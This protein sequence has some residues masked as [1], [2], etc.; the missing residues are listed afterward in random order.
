MYNYKYN[1][2]ELQETGMYD[3]GAR[4]Y[5][6]DIGRWGV[7][8]PLAEKYRR[9]STYAY[10]VNNPIRFI[11]PD[12]RQ[13]MDPI[14][15]RISTFKNGLKLIGDDGKN[16]GRAYIAMGKIKRAVEAT[17]KKGE[18]YKG[19]LAEGNNVAIIPTGDRLGV[20]VQSFEDTKKS[21]RENGGFAMKGQSVIRSDEGPAARQKYENG[22]V[23]TEA[24]LQPFKVGGQDVR[25]DNLSNMEMVWHIHPDVT[26]HELS[27][28]P[29]ELGH[30]SPSDADFSFQK[31]LEE[32]GYTGNGFVIGTQ[33][34]SVT[35]YNGKSTITN[36]NYDDWKNA[37]IRT[38]MNY[39]NYINSLLSNLKP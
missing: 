37:G 18:I 29:I 30:S 26:L 16:K 11:D 2:K 28:L 13:V 21:G 32:D 6:P 15:G 34:N 23:V 33:S 22:K 39:M 7:V 31:G 14:Y 1:G 9:H 24:W 19:I 20:V 10:A 25:P 36:I 35:Y 8:D 5:M 17:T 27:Q 3:Y 12:G 4:F 38:T